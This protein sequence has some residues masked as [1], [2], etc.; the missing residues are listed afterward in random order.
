[1]AN[2]KS[3]DS[4]LDR[5]VRILSAFDGSRNSMTVSALARLA[6][7]PP[8]TAYRLVDE[9]VRRDLL[10]RSEG[11]QVSLGLRLWELAS[12]SSPAV[13]LREAARPFMEDI[14]AVVRQHTQLAVLRDDEVLFIE[15]L[16]SRVSVVNPARVAGRLPVH[17][18]S[19]GVVLLAYAPGHIQEAYLTR[20]PDAAVPLDSVSIDLRQLLARVRQQGYAALDGLVDTETS[21]VAV[22][23][24]GARNLAIAALSVVVPLLGDNL[25]SILPVLMAGS[26]GISRSMGVVPKPEQAII[27]IQ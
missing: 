7:I 11:G 8:A 23:V 5:F 10:S 19:S 22:P 14:Q 16:S 26:R 20:H 4:M 27:P 13:D 17:R 12:R 21:G 15:R 2:S 6:D 25:H 3:G 24:L 1:M 9:L 18:T